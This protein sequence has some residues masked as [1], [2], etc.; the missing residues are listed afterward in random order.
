M[1]SDNRAGRTAGNLGPVGH[2]GLVSLSTRTR[3]M[4]PKGHDLRALSRLT[5]VV[6]Y[7]G[8]TGGI[9]GIQGTGHEVDDP[10]AIAL[11]SRNG[12]SGLLLGPDLLWIRGKADVERDEPGAWQVRIE[13]S[14]PEVQRVTRSPL[15]HPSDSAPPHFSVYLRL[16]SALVAAKWTRTFLVVA[17]LCELAVSD[18]A[19][20]FE[21][22]AEW[23]RR[24]SPWSTV[25]TPLLMEIAQS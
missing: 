6:V 11:T 9:D 5:G 21:T 16:E 15:W 13:V 10:Y 7:R 17:G 2:R 25:A 14:G 8:A 12:I 18:S 19:V 20:T 24:D 22:V 23:V 4:A 3:L 1:R